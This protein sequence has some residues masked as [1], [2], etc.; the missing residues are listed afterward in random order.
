MIIKLLRIEEDI[1]C[2]NYEFITLELLDRSFFRAVLREISGVISDVKELIIVDGKTP[3]DLSKDILVI[4]N[5]FLFDIRDKNIQN[6]LYKYLEKDVMSDTIKYNQ[7]NKAASEFA[8]QLE[9]LI[10]DNTFDLN[11]NRVPPFRECLKCFGIGLSS[12]TD[13][14]ELSNFLRANAALKIYKAIIAVNCK[15]FL[16]DKELS[17]LTKEISATETRFVFLENNKYG[18]RF[19]NEKK[20]FVDKDSFAVIK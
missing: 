9:N 2:E 14:L 11:N 1:I 20:L 10:I 12:Q 16:S 7:F 18:K 6:S 15:S 3:L 17:E 19:D 13:I 4:Y 8:L 5:P